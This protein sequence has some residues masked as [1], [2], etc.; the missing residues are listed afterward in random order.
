MISLENM[1]SN[2]HF[3]KWSDTIFHFM[4]KYSLSPRGG[5]AWVA[6]SGG[7]D[8]ILLLSTLYS[9]FKRGRLK[10]LKILHFNHQTRPECEEEEDLVTSYSKLLQL[11]LVTETPT[12]TLG[13]S[14]LEH[15]AREERYAFF[16]RTIERG[17]RVYLG[18]HLNDSLEWSLMSRFKS[19]RLQS[20]LGMP[21]INGA[22]ARPFFC[23]TRDQIDKMGKNLGLKWLEDRTNND[24]RFERNFLR[25][26]ILPK[27]EQRFPGYMRHYVTSS[28]HLARKLGLWRRNG[29][30]IFE[31][32]N[33]P[34]GGVGLFHSHLKNTF[35][36]AEELIR[37]IVEKLSSAH[38]GSLS[39]QIDKMIEAASRGRRGPIFFSGSVR[40]YITQGMLFFIHS[41]ELA[42]WEKYDDAIVRALSR[43]KRLERI[44]FRRMGRGELIEHINQMPFPP[45]GVE[46]I[47]EGQHQEEQH[48]LLPQTASLFKKKG[49]RL[50]S[51]VKKARGMQ[52]NGVKGQ[53]LPLDLL[54]RMGNFY[55]AEK[56]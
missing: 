8:S 17:D 27:I 34:L 14:N 10:D 35:W 20:Q 50:N 43:R 11:P 39:A 42:G 26:K 49:W 47:Q 37:E 36:G 3:M 1:L 56:N 45:M 24:T 12:T 16:K 9:L 32:R 22:F 44:P 2:Y 33:L 6:V 46:R 54:A 5:S 15:M 7:R 55:C 13:N 40:G 52:K 4:S 19:S 25:S 48:L 31:Q 28:N 51:L 21:V 23:V 38:R 53:I 29:K 18:H 30:Q 41:R